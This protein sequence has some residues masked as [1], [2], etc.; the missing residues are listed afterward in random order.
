MDNPLMVQ[1]AYKMQRGSACSCV[2]AAQKANKCGFQN[3]KPRILAA[4]TAEVTNHATF[5]WQ[6]LPIKRVCCSMS[7]VYRA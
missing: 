6:D 7:G 4:A 1:A 3:R 5:A 2:Q